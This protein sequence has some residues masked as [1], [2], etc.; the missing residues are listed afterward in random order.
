MVLSCRI[1]DSTDTAPCFKKQGMTWFRCK[2]CRFVFT[3][4]DKNANFETHLEDYETSYLQYLED[5]PE[6]LINLEKLWRWMSHFIPGHHKEDGY[7]QTILDVGCGSGKLVR[8]LRSRGIEALGTEPA[9]V[10]YQ[11]YLSPDDFFL[12]LPIEELAIH[13]DAPRFQIISAFD[14]LEHVEWPG[15]FM[16]AVV[17]LLEPGGLLF[18]S[19]P[20]LGS[21]PAKILGQN[22]HFINKYHL[23]LFS[24]AM[25][26][27]LAGRY[28]LQEIACRH[29]GRWRSLG[30]TARYAGE[31]L[32]HRP[33][34]TLPPFLDR[35]VIPINLFD[36]MYLCF[37]KQTV[38]AEIREAHLPL[39]KPLRPVR[40]L[41][42]SWG[43]VSSMNTR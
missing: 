7:H 14:V 31:F 32:L 23:S 6:D 37:K 36:T 19:T 20:D 33:I 12:P 41:G 1:C 8:F 43:P 28:G 26:H 27:A 22:W 16:E 9:E 11:H 2:V 17:R 30:Y 3:S 10:L 13:P 18:L 38:D 34:T 40:V 5:S 15:L 35:M 29:R 21:L 4:P 39:L 24:H 25:L 42:P